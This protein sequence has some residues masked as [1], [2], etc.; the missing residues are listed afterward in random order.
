[1]EETRRGQGYVEA[2]CSIGQ[3]KVGGVA[4]LKAKNLVSKYRYASLNDG[5]TF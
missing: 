3:G 5:D 1:M 4:P 2:N